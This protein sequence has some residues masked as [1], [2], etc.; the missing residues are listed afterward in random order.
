LGPF[1]V[2]LAPFGFGLTT[3]GVDFCLRVVYLGCFGVNLRPLGVVVS[4]G[5]AFAPLWC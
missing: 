1:G 4:F 2:G 3:F 5:I